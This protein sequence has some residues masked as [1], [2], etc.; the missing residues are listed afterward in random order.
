MDAKVLLRVGAAVFVALAF[1]VASLQALWR[2]KT[3]ASSPAQLQIPMSDPMREAQRRCQQLG[4][5]AASNPECLAVWAETRDRFLGR[6][7]RPPAR[8]DEDR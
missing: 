7:P 4:Q 3:P 8:T 1:T 5:E 2:D 6:V